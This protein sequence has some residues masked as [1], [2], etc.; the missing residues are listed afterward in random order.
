MESR[1]AS[2]ARGIID[3]QSPSLFLRTKVDNLKGQVPHL[4]VTFVGVLSAN[5]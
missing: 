2:K 5:G 4:D 1:E 3:C